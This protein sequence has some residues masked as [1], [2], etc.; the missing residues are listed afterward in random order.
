MEVGHGVVYSLNFIHNPMP[1][2][3]NGGGGFT[4]NWFIFPPMIRKWVCDKMC[5]GGAKL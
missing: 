2:N 3:K 1:A 4:Y 5:N